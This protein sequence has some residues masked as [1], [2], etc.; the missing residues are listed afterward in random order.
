MASLLFKQMCRYL[1]QSSYNVR[2]RAMLD[3][4]YPRALQWCSTE[5]IPDDVVGIDICICCTPPRHSCCE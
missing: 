3:E 1:P 4:Y 2:T 5:E